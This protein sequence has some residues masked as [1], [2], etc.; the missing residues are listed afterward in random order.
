MTGESLRSQPYQP[1]YLRHLTCVAKTEWR[2]ISNGRGERSWVVLVL[3]LTIF[4]G[5]SV[6]LALW[7]WSGIEVAA[8]QYLNENEGDWRVFAP[9]QVMKNGR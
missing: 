8:F 4:E 7:L 2:P 5:R 1:L 6:D 9:A 3:Q